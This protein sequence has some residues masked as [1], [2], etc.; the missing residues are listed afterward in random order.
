MGFRTLGFRDRG[1]LLHPLLVISF[2]GGLCFT[3]LGYKGT[4]PTC[5][6]GFPRRAEA[7]KTS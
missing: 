3:H 2:T 6:G 7:E 4:F 1:G 5:F